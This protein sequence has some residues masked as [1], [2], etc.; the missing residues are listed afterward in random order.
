MNDPLF[1]VVLLH[2]NQPQYLRRALLSVLEQNYPQIELLVADDAS[3]EFDRAAVCA[4]IDAHK[5]QN[6]KNWQIVAGDENVG[7]VANLNRVLP[8]TSGACVLCFA[9]D[10]ALYDE[11]VLS[12]FAQGLAESGPDTLCVSAQ[13]VMMDAELS[14]ET[15]VFTDAA[16]AQKLNGETARAQ[17]H[18]LQLEPRYALGASAF[19]REALLA[20]TPAFDPAYRLIEDWPF[21]LARTRAGQSVRFLPFPALRHRAGGVSDTA[22]QSESIHR[23]FKADMLHI[24]EREI[25]PSL[26]EQPLRQQEELLRRYEAERA[27]YE[28]RHG[29]WAGPSRRALI[30][31]HKAL[32]ARR[33][34]WRRHAV[35]KQS[36]VQNCKRF[37]AVWCAWIITGSLGMKY[38]G[39]SDSLLC[40]APA[41][42]LAALLSRVVFPCAALL[43]ALMVLR[44]FAI[45][46][47]VAAKRMLARK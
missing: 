24:W 8:Q 34:L 15:G 25:L 28:A 11:T 7:T 13:C 30:F 17:F 32:F 37:L 18:A 39:Q 9:A 5:R 4:F 23:Q 19:L 20:R 41:A 22:R 31:A 27:A 1:S 29:A 14:A 35:W 10:D 16:L 43:C 12:R 38:F 21:F 40:G 42:V 3:P 2:Y 36:L 46:S 45:G 6:L 33:W 44:D 47:L 26:E